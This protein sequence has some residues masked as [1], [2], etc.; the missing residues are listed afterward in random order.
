M[1]PPDRPEDFSDAEY[2]ELCEMQKRADEHGAIANPE[3]I[4][5]ARSPVVGVFVNGLPIYDRSR[6]INPTVPI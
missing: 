4:R 6:R 3:Y 5:I 2:A 1:N